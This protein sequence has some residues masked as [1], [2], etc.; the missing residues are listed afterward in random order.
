MDISGTL[1][2]YYHHCHRQVWLFMHK[3]FMEQNSET[4]HSGKYLSEKAFIKEHH[5]VKIGGGVLDFYDRKTH[6]INEIKHSE[7]M[8]ELHIK[9]MQYYVY[10]L[11]ELGVFN[12]KGIIRYPQQRTKREVTLSQTDRKEIDITII[13]IKKIF[14]AKQP[15][16]VINEPYCKK[17]AYYDLCYT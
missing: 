4:V 1:I 12:V 11:E 8:S 10:L 3:V 16:P 13:E 7:S 17:C 5:E 9:Q 15:P 14:Y 2:N 6:T